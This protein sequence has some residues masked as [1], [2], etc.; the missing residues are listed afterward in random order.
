M[1][2]NNSVNLQVTRN[3]DGFD[4]SGGTTARKMTVTSGDITLT[5][6]G[7]YTYTFP[8][9]TDTLVSLTSTAALTNKT[10][11]APKIESGGFIADANGNE[12]VKFTTTASAVNEFTV[13]NA[14]ANGAPSIAGTGGDTNIAVTLAGKGT[15]A[16]NLG[17]ATCIGVK[18]VA[19]QPILDANGNEEIKFVAT[20]SAVNEIT[21]TNAATTGA[22]SI[23]STGGD[24]NI[25]LTVAGKGTGAINLGQATSTGV[26]LVA[27]QPIL[28][29]SDN[30]LVKFSKAATAVNEVTIGN[31]ATGNGPTFS[32]TGGDTN[33]DL[34]LT[35]KG[36]GAVNLPTG[37]NV[38]VNG[39][40]PKRS[41]VLT[42]AGG[43]PSTTSGCAAA[44]LSEASTNKQNTFSLDFDKA[45][46]EN[47]E[48]TV[49][50]PDN[51]DGS[52]LTAKFF[53]TAAAGT[54]G[55]TVSINI[56]GRAYAND[57]AIDQAWG[58]A[59]AV[60]D[61]LIATGDVHVTSE[62]GAITLAG[63]PAG[64]QLVQFRVYRDVSEDDLDADMKLLA[65]RIE[66]GVS[67]FSD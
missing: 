66:Y 15:G 63:S 48:W 49:V 56:Q 13:T 42:A 9:V 65:C 14:A 23:A 53:W 3:A 37:C 59:V 60:S 5:G 33:I 11:T 35:P 2:T 43:W 1:A 28:D 57:D 62:S 20:G 17:Q 24:T 38:K 51:Y 39:A 26:K 67:A 16:I 6:G 44:A 54:A 19:S 50:M 52:T 41:I 36:T 4:I 58:T 7:G 21:V 10:L 34:N 46:D 29:S 61:A 64:G 40:N 18:L 47:A 12:Q 25:A 55:Q 31:A 22:P 27:D 8:P 30:E 32:A 45:S